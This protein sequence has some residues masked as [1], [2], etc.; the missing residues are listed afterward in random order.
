MSIL[1]PGINCIGSYAATSTG[2]IVDARDYYRAVYHA[3]SAAKRYL[4]FTG[5]QFDSEVSLLR[6]KDAEQAAGE[7]RFLHF[8]EQLCETKPELEIY[9]LAWDFSMIFSMEREWF[10]DII[11]NW[12]T[13]KRIHFRFDNR[14]AVGA[15][16]H[17]KLVV[18]DGL[19]AFV[20][21]MD[22]CADRWD[23]RRHLF[24]N[25]DRA[26]TNGPFSS[27]HDIQSFHTGPVV[28]ELVAIFNQRW[29][30][31]G[32]EP[33]LLKSGDGPIPLEV[34]HLIPLSTDRV[35]VS[36]TQALNFHPHQNG[37]MEI[38]SLFTRAINSAQRLIY[39]EN[40]YFS[41]QSIFA[42]LVQ[43]MTAEDR[44]RLQIVMLLPNELPLTEKLF[45]GRTQMKMLRALQ[46]VAIDT[47]HELGVY[48]TACVKDGI[49]QMTFIHS[50]LLLVDD[51]FLSIGS[52]NITNRSMGLDTELNVS[53][54]AST[55]QDPL[56]ASIR[57][58]RASL[59][60]EHAGLHGRGM[61][62]NFEKIDGL[63]SC[64]DR[65]ADDPEMRVCR[66]EPDPTM[67][68]TPWEDALDSVA[69]VVD[70]LEHDYEE[71]TVSRDS[72]FTKGIHQLSQWVNSLL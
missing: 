14:H 55:G 64:L 59:L 15:T 50:K 19:L 9:I 12:T 67:E 68:N 8:L 23:D 51:C 58:V 28:Q 6:G 17:Q 34:E 37:I 33:I 31:S 16:H 38:R 3:A 29:I 71:I 39:L 43:R 46:Q 69:C 61:E 52:A 49:R 2:V 35:A 65:L 13:N 54:E 42:A 20:G 5:W 27:Y 25:P 60:A 18:V 21:G 72:V 36:R 44:S 47:G 40:Q 62:Q 10:Q 53:W 45:L 56:I 4:L 30:N 1:E 11:F 32:A 26:D 41:S 63:V 22:I 70:P 48:S 24:E 66:Y 57:Q 7:V